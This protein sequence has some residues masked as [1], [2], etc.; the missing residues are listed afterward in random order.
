MR[1]LSERL[2]SKVKIDNETDC[3]NWTG[4]KRGGYGQIMIDKTPRGAHCVSYEIHRGTIPAGIFV[5]HQCDNRACVNPAHL[6]L[7][8]AA[9]NAADRDAK[10]RQIIFNGADHGSAKLSEADVIAIRSSSESQRK[11]GQRYGISG[12]QVCRIRTGKQ[13]VS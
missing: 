11:L 8:S 9:D 7:G 13:W 2:L 6:F 12:S 10:G 4:S 5:C 1:S 3:W